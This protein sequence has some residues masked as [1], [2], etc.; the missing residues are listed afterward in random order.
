MKWQHLFVLACVVAV[1]MSSAKAQERTGAQ[2]EVAIDG[3]IVARP[4]MRVLSGGEGRLELSE[5]HGEERVTF[6]PTVRGDEVAIAFDISS[7]GRQFRPT[8]VITRTI[9][10]SLEWTSSTRAQTIRL[11]VSLVQ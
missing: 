2:F 6:T 1:G 8:L 5:V 11:T 7:G 4:E 9:P 10:G 3:S